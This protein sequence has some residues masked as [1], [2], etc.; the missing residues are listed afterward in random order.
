MNIN[1]LTVENVQLPVAGLVT[2]DP[3]CS[4]IDADT[5]GRTTTG[6]MVRKVVRKKVYHIALKW[7]DIP[8]ADFETIMQAIDKKTLAVSFYFGLESNI[9]CNM[10]HTDIK[11]S[12][13]R[14]DG[15]GNTRWDL[16]FDLVQY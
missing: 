12:L 9:S 14:T 16:S 15:D 7:E 11:S 6:K 5:S 10:Y 3:E 2:F 4:A 1:L 8:A 13:K